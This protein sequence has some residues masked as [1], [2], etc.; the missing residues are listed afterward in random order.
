MRDA[1]TLPGKD[2]NSGFV[3]FYLEFF[4]ENYRCLQGNRWKL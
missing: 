4:E 1:V 2:V 3:S